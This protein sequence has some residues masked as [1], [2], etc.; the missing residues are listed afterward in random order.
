MITK[1]GIYSGGSRGKRKFYP[2][3]VSPL[4][5]QR[6]VRTTTYQGKYV[7]EYSMLEVNRLTICNVPIDIPHKLRLLREYLLI[8]MYAVLR[9]EE[10]VVPYNKKEVLFSAKIVRKKVGKIWYERTLK[11]LAKI[12]NVNNERFVF[13][14]YSRYGKLND[15]E[16][17]QSYREKLLYLVT[18]QDMA[19]IYPQTVEKK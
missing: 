19:Y 18:N 1:N 9:G 3:R 17:G 10:W 7:K 8:M 15:I 13:S 4:R 12:R 5:K 11:S 6:K 2:K 14:F 16:A